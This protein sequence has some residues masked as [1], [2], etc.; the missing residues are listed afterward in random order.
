MTYFTSIKQAFENYVTRLGRSR[1]NK[2]LLS[3]SD[4]QLLDVGISRE[5]LKSGSNGW[6]WKFSDKSS[7]YS[8]A[9]PAAS[10]IRKAIADLNAYNDTELADLGL[11]R[12]GI[13]D[14]VRFGRAGIEHTDVR[15]AA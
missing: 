9:T 8:L 15:Q 2:I 6:P 13:V 3:Y 11:S 5:L 7:A 14:A 12:G 10:D 4:R 1:A